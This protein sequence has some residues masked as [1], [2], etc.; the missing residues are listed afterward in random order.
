M[1]DKPQISII[2][3]VYNTE[4][5][6]HRCIDSIL[7]QTFTN[8]ELLLI[9]DGSKDSS[10]AICDEYA[11]KDIR[12]RVFHKPNGGVSSA[13][14]MGI[15]NTEGDWITFVDSDD[16]VDE[17]WLENYDLDSDADVQIQGM[18]FVRGNEILKQ[19]ELP[20]IFYTQLDW[21]D[22]FYKLNLSERR[23]LFHYP[24]T[25]LYRQSI[26][27]KFSLRFQDNIQLAEDLLFNLNYY[28]CCMKIELVSY[29]S[30]N[31]LIGNSVLTNL[32]YD[33]E[34]LMQ[35]N[36]SFYPVIAKIGEINQKASDYLL[37][38]RM[39]AVL[40][41]AF[42]HKV[43]DLNS[44]IMA[45]KYYEEYRT[46]GMDN[47]LQIPYKIVSLIRKLPILLQVYLLC[48][49]FFMLRPFR[50]SKY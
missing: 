13:R 46:V 40:N 18:K 11:N 38:L 6:L 31:Y 29:V 5:Y 24:F 49:V 45:L 33:S 37:S 25:K 36:E 26:I 9:D 3:P 23:L 17:K 28:L 7:A 4:K 44:K 8:F 48:F 20:S 34:T 15:E 30:Y 16:C 47:F 10:G 39:T 32:Q 43:V 35:W 14:N 41:A 12:I 19:I 27:N 42:R 2:V 22:L 50:R 21:F 1:N